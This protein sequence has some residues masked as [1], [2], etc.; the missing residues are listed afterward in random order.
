MPDNMKQTVE[1]LPLLLLRFPTVVK[2]N[3]TTQL[4]R[5]EHKISRKTGDLSSCP[6]MIPKE[7]DA[8]FC[9]W[10]LTA[11]DH[12]TEFPVSESSS[13][14]TNAAR[15]FKRIRSNNSRVVDQL[16]TK[17]ATYLGEDSRSW[18]DAT[19]W[20]KNN[21]KMFDFAEAYLHQF[22]CTISTI[23]ISVIT[24]FVVD[25]YIR[26]FKSEKKVLQAAFRSVELETIQN[27]EWIF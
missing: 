13:W 1:C 17:L 19:T 20:L 14:K 12:C 25:A 22:M 27:I 9:G 18:E 7:I 8:K 11:L 3:I 26:H 16:K 6:E 24:S 21:A 5:L 23:P 2:H 4:L 15:T 10:V